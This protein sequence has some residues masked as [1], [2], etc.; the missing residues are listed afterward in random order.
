[1]T[2]ADITRNLI[3]SAAI[4]ALF[5]VAYLIAGRAGRR[6]V[7]RISRQGEPGTRAATLW[8]MVRRLLLVAVV[9]TA[10]LTVLAAV[11]RLPITP[12][13]AVGSAVGVALG[14]GAQRLVQDVIAGFFLLLED[15]FR[16]GDAVSLAAVSGE[17]QDIRLRITVIRDLN[18]NV[19]YVP[20]GDI[21]VA[22]NMSQGYGQVVLD[23]SLS[24]ENDLDR[25]IGVLSDEL[26]AMA[27]DEQWKASFLSQPEV[28]GVERLAETA[29]VIRALAKVRTGD[30]WSV[31]REALRRIKNRFEKESIS[32]PA[33]PLS[34][35]RKDG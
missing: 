9:I 25:A 3:A 22:T 1:M 31:Q 4:L 19:H 24:Y 18:G 5:A 17:V 35:Y 26:E 27:A 20:N 13:L 7:E 2:A 33:M 34:V 23:L 29:I 14:F 12:F 21:R 28:L 30:R 32:L 16:I 15:Q 11:W 8:S 6:F 10:V